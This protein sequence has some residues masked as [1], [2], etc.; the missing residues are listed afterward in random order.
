MEDC[1]W[2]TNLDRH[3]RACTL[4]ENKYE[5]NDMIKQNPASHTIEHKFNTNNKFA[6]IYGELAAQSR[7]YIPR[8][9]VWPIS[10]D[11]LI[12]QV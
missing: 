12:A 7:T 10:Q 5:K 3:I 4:Q 1:G 8:T 6:E 9:H 2:K 11:F